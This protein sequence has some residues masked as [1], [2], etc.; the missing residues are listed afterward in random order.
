MSDN[1][2]KVD[3]NA[4]KGTKEYEFLKAYYRNRIRL[5]DMTVQEV[6]EELGLT[7]ATVEDEIMEQ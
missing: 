2:V 1:N 3:F 4:K 6:A 5:G 7:D